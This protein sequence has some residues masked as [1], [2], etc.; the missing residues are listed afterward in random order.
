MQLTSEQKAAVR[1]GKPVHLCEDDLECVIVRADVF[2][3]FQASLV[4]DL[5]V[6]A[7]Y[8]LV[9]EVLADDDAHDPLL[10]SYQ[11]YH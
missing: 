6:T 9:N 8:P 7:A 10:E 11:T 4:P 1:D 2:E 5:D 3:R